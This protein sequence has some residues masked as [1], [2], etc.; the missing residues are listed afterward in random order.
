MWPS[1]WLLLSC[2]DELPEGHSPLNA[3][4][5]ACVWSLVRS[6]PG[7]LQPGPR[8]SPETGPRRVYMGE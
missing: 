8:S 6:P 4:P 2:L 7:P 1:E 3:S 5:E